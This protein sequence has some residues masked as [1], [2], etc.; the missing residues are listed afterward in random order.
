MEALIWLAPRQPC[1]EEP[2]SARPSGTRRHDGLK[3]GN[4]IDSQDP[5]DIDEILKI[6]PSR[7]NDDD[8]VA[9]FLRS[10]EC[11]RSKVHITWVYAV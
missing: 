3:L 8:F 6:Q 7:R 1:K 11:S 5:F 2:A 9:W 4:L 10:V